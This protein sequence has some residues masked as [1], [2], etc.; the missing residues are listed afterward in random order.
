MLGDHCALRLGGNGVNHLLWNDVGV[1]DS[2][3]YAIDSDILFLIIV[4][5][6]GF[7]IDYAWHLTLT[8]FRTLAVAR[9]KFRT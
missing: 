8:I 1:Y 7:L 2:R 9:I 4:S 6:P 5:S 3:E